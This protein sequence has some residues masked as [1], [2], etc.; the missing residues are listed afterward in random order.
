[1][2]LPISGAIQ[3]SDINTELGRTATAQLSI[4]DSE[5]RELFGQASGAVDL[6]TG[7]GKSSLVPYVTG[8]FG[9][10]S[11]A[12]SNI[13][14]YGWG[15]GRELYASQDASYPQYAA[16]PY[17]TKSKP[18]GNQIR[19]GSNSV[20]IHGVAYYN[21][22]TNVDSEYDYYTVSYAPWPGPLGNAASLEW[23]DTVTFSNGAESLTFSYRDVYGVVAYD[24]YRDLT[25]YTTAPLGPNVTLAAAYTPISI[26]IGNP[27][28]VTF[29][30]PTGLILSGGNQVLTDGPNGANWYVNGTSNI[31]GGS[32]INASGHASEY[33][34][35][36]DQYSYQATVWD[37]F[38][39]NGNGISPGGRNWVSM[40]N[41]LK[42]SA[43]YG[44]PGNYSKIAYYYIRKIGTVSV[45]ATGYFQMP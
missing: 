19:V 7:H 32:W 37:A 28:T 34:F 31:A 13:V 29:T 17:G 11:S 10:I 21:D 14:A 30:P 42:I 38:D 16:G 41:G 15:T 4:N 39:Q 1:M 18:T 12:W 44:T 26:S 22:N 27:F 20:Y 35:T 43:P 40:A 24:S 25:K 2:T 9:Y 23:F 36:L 5:L 3:F 8:T 45:L 6:N 33:E